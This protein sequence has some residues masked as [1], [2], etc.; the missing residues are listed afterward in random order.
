MPQNRPAQSSS[1]FLGG[2]NWSLRE[3]SVGCQ[4]VGV[5]TH[6]MAIWLMVHTCFKIC[7]MCYHQ[8]MMYIQE[9]LVGV[10]YSIYCSN[11]NKFGWYNN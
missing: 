11:Q 6:V 2:S 8:M 7:G 9:P 1:I 3:E 5:T 4:G 10:V